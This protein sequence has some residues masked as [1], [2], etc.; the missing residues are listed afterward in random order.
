MTASSVT[1]GISSHAD[2]RKWAWWELPWRVR[3]YVGLVPSAACI[4]MIVAAVETTWHATD[5]IKFSLLLACGVVSVIATPRIAYLH[6]GITKDFLPVWLLP[7]AILTPPFY[8]MVAPVPL[9]ALTQWRVHRGV[10]YR[11][12][13]TASAMA[14]CYG[15][16][17]L[18]FRAFPASFAGGA[19]GTDRHVLTWVVAVVAC[20]L[21][22]WLGHDLFIVG[23]IK[24]SDPSVGMAKLLI[25]REALQSDV[26]ELDLGIVVTIVVAVN[27]ALAVCAVPTVLLIRRFM[28][29]EQLLAQARVDTKTGLLN[30]STWEAEAASELTRAIRMHAPLSVAL[31]DIDHFKRVNDTYGHLVGDVVLRAVTDAIR[32]H[33]RNYDLAGRFGGEEF[34]VLL[35]Q[36]GETDAVNVAERLRTHIAGLR[37]PVDPDVPDGTHVRLTISVGVAALD[38]TRRELTNLMAAADAA[39]YQAKQSGRNQTRVTPAQARAI[40]GS[41]ARAS[42]QKLLR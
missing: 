25:N 8:A 34:V 21:V 13:F 16:A 20:E 4:L 18:A 23:A 29:H 2:F 9:L 17:S 26:A 19:I 41:A 35:P 36:A 32:E 1:S 28:M 30:A 31:I 37:I 7:V 38:D 12:V 24:L 22:G 27:P 33:L 3:V 40:A 11:R 5:L 10:L 15:A 42:D 39:L 6:G 14:L